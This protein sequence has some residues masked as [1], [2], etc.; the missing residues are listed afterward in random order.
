VGLALGQYYSNGIPRTRRSSES[1]LI[2]R[3]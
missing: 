2:S 1:S 3:T